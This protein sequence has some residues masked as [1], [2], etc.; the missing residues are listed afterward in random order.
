[1]QEQC[2][3]ATIWEGKV[4]DYTKLDAEFIAHDRTDDEMIDGNIGWL[5]LL[6]PGL[7]ILGIKRGKG[8]TRLGLSWSTCTAFQSQ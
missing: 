3:T 5:A 7:L 6:T 2:C 8:H 4:T 1:M